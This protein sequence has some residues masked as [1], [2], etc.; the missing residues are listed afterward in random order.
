MF[1]TDEFLQPIDMHSNC[2]TYV[3]GCWSLYRN[4]PQMASLF[5]EERL[6]QQELTDP[7]PSGWAEREYS[8]LIEAQ[9]N[10]GRLVK[11]WTQWQVFEEARLARLRFDEEKLIVDRTEVMMAHFRRTKVYPPG[12]LR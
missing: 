12:C 8:K 7:L 10:E 4:T 11:E 6:W 3:N 5:M 1:V 2:S 9:H